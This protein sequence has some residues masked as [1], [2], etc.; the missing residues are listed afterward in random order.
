MRQGSV[1]RPN[2]HI[3]ILRHHMNPGEGRSTEG[4]CDVK[5]RTERS[6]RGGVG[7]YFE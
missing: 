4:T 6:G 7:A 1:S 3:V 5:W 2:V